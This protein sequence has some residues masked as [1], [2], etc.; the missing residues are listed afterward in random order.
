[1]TLLILLSSVMAYAQTDKGEWKRPKHNGNIT[2]EFDKTREQTK[3]ELGL[4]PVTCVRD[5]CIFISLT[6]FFHGSKPKAPVDNIIFAVSIVTKTLKPF[7]EPKLLLVLD[8]APMVLGEM[9]FAGEVPAGDLT[10]MPY[11]IH[12][13]GDELAKIA[14][15]HRVEAQIGGLRFVLGENELNAIRDYNHQLR[16]VQL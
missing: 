13:T 3:V 1:L 4:M 14:D 8:G 16:A 15:A 9:T 10:G 5:G 6:W 2:T 7:A 11:G 12:I